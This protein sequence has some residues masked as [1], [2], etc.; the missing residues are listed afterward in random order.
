MTDYALLKLLHMSSA[1]ISISLFMLRGLWVLR[2]LAVPGRALKILPHIND[3]LLLLS[4]I[5]LALSTHQYPLE[6]DWLTLKVV[7]LVIYIGLGLLAMR[8]GKTLLQRRLAWLLAVLVF[9]AIAL[10][11]ISKSPWPSAWLM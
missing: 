3:S 10:T 7:L 1:G 5:M 8:L 6:Q 2:D 4:A 11:A 9:A